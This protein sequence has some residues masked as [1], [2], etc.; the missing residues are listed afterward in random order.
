MQLKYDDGKLS[1]NA[2]ELIDHMDENAKQN[3]IEILACSDKV[4]EYVI[5]QV[6]DGWTENGSHGGRLCT[7]SDSPARGLDW[8]VRE[9]AKRSGDVAEKEI[10]RLESAIRSE[11]NVIKGLREQLHAYDLRHRLAW[12]T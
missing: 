1:F 8:A 3:V 12:G 7:A 4:I 2:V 10:E 11:Q 9:V 6:L 5:A